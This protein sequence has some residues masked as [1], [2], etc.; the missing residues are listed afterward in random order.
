[1]QVYRRK[2]NLSLS[3]CALYAIER[4][5]NHAAQ[6]MVTGMKKARLMPKRP[7]EVDCMK[8][9]HGRFVFSA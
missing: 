7:S 6:L 2:D 5:K 9:V 3:V 8:S 1:M 4:Y